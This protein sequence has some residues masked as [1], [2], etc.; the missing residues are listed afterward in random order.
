MYDAYNNGK[1]LYAII[2]QSAFHNDYY[3]NLEFNPEGRI[4]EVDGKKIVAGSGKEKQLATENNSITVPYFYLVPT[5]IGELAASEL[6]SGMKV[7]SSIGELTVQSTETAD[8]VQ[9]A[10]GEAAQIKI[11]FVES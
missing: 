2:A 10:G 5:N 4:I 3:D 9:L 1:D 11:N 6:K 8:T 7:I